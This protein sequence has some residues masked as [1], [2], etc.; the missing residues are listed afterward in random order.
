M[1]LWVL[2]KY[3][4]SLDEF[5]CEDFEDVIQLYSAHELQD[6]INRYVCLH[7]VKRLDLSNCELKQCP[8]VEVLPNLQSLN[9]DGNKITH[10]AGFE[11]NEN[12]KMLSV[13][14][15]LLTAVNIPR[16]SLTRINVG[17]DV[18]KF[19]GTQLLRA[20]LDGFLEIDVIDYHAEKLLFPKQ[21]I[22]Q[23][24]SK[25]EAFVKNPLQ[26]VLGIRD[27]VQRR[28][29]LVWMFTENLHD[30][31]DLDLSEQGEIF[32]DMPK[33]DVTAVLE[34]DCL[35]HLRHLK[36]K[37]CD[38]RNL[39]K[40]KIFD[41]LET[42]DI[43]D[44]FLD[45]FDLY[46]DSETQ[47][48]H[49]N[50]DGNP[51]ERIEID[52][53]NLPHLEVLK[54]GSVSTKYISIP[55]LERHLRGMS[56]EIEQK[57]RASLL[58]PSYNVIENDL[59][60]AFIANPEKY[61][62]QISDLSERINVL[63]WYRKDQESFRLTG[64]KDLCMEESSL[65]KLL[66]EPNLARIKRLS[67]D[68]CGLTSLPNVKH[69]KNLEVL[70][71]SENA[72]SDGSMNYK[73]LP[74]SL[75]DLDIA[76]NPIEILE[77]DAEV[78][79]SWKARDEKTLKFRC[80]SRHTK[81]ISFAL[82]D[83]FQNDIVEIKVDPEFTD[84]LL[85]P[86]YAILN[87]PNLGE[88][89]VQ[90]EQSLNNVENERDLK[91]VLHWLF[92]VEHKEFHT[93]FTICNPLCSNLNIINYFNDNAFEMVR[94]MS[95]K[96]QLSKP[97]NLSG[98]PKLTSRLVTLD[99]SDN[100]IRDLS[101]GFC[102]LKLLDTLQINDNPLEIIDFDL[103]LFP[104][105]T[106]LVCGSKETKYFR[107]SLLRGLVAQ[108]V[109]IEI[110]GDENNFLFPGR[111]YIKQG[112]EALEALCQNPEKAL[113]A[114][115]SVN[116]KKEFLDWLLRED[117]DFKSFSLVG[118][119]ELWNCQS[120]RN[121]L[122]FQLFRIE[123][124][125]L[126]SCN[127][128]E[129][130]NIK[131]YDKLKLLDLSNNSITDISNL[132][133]HKKLETFILKGNPIET[134]DSDFKCFPALSRI[135]IGSLKTHYIG[136]SLLRRMAPEENTEDIKVSVVVSCHEQSLLMPH[137]NL[138]KYGKPN[139]IQHYIKNPEQY[140]RKIPKP[141]HQ[142][143]ALKWI[144]EYHAYD[145]R[146]FQLSHQ[147]LLCKA[148]GM[149]NLNRL[150]SLL[151]NVR[152]INLQGCRLTEVPE[153][154]SLKEL[155]SLDLGFNEI[156]EM[157]NTFSHEKLKTLNIQANLIPNI[158]TDR[159][160]S[161]EE[162]HCGSKHTKSISDLAL[163][164]IK[165][166]SLKIKI[167]PSFRG[168]LQLPPYGVLDG[169]PEDIQT[170]L[171]K[172][173][174]DLSDIRTK[175]DIELYSQSSKVKVYKTL[176]MS[177]SSC[178][179]ELRNNSEFQNL[180]RQLDNI[181]S[182][183]FQDC[184]FN[185]FPTEFCFPKL[186]KI[187]LSNS[188][189]QQKVL[190]GIP[191]SVSKFVARN[192]KLR[193]LP[194]C[195]GVESLDVRENEISS[196]SSLVA[197]ARLKSLAIE[198]NRLVVVD[199]DRDIFPKLETLTCGSG[200]CRFINFS[201]LQ[202]VLSGSLTLELSPGTNLLLPPKASLD[203]TD[204]LREYVNGPERFLNHLP[205][206]DAV[207][208]LMW[209][210]AESTSNF[211]SFDLSGYGQLIEDLG[212]D[213]FQ[214]VLEME[215]LRNIKVLNLSQNSLKVLPKINCLKQVDTL[216]LSQ[217]EL[218]KFDSLL[219]HPSLTKLCLEG[220]P[221]SCLELNTELFPGLRYIRAG[222]RE[223]HTVE[224]ALL[225]QVL[226]GKI[227]L[228]IP[229]D[230]R[231]FLKFPTYTSLCDKDKLHKYLNTD[232]LDLSVSEKG[233]MRVKLIEDSIKKCTLDIVA[234]NVSGQMKL[235]EK[236]ESGLNQLLGDQNLRNVK[237][238][239]MNSCGISHFPTLK[240]MG[241][242]THL[243]LGGNQFE[244]FFINHSLRNLQ[245][246][247]LSNC[248]LDRMFSLNHFPVLK[249]LDIS[250]NRIDSDK[251][252]QFC[253]KSEKVYQLEKLNI[254]GNP[255]RE[256]NF[257]VNSFP[258][259]KEIKAGSE[260]TKFI[261]FPVLRHVANNSLSI[262]IPEHYQK[263]LLLCPFKVLNGG[264]EAINN[265]LKDTEINL[266]YIT[267]TSDRFEA[268]NWLLVHKDNTVLGVNFSGQKDFF[269]FC[270][271]K[272]NY[273]YG[274]FDNPL[275]K[276]V[277]VVYLDNC[278]LTEIP[279]MS[280]SLPKLKVLYLSNNKLEKIQPPNNLTVFQRNSSLEKLLID[281]NPVEIIDITNPSDNFPELRVLQVGSKGTHFL[282]RT[283]IDAA[284]RTAKPL[285]VK[286]VEEYGRYMTTPPYEII[287]AGPESL[288]K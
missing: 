61:S 56:L 123:S 180:F 59:V 84:E 205:R 188:D 176:R 109:T 41:S 265:Y 212:H 288:S 93:T 42:L 102:K 165:D 278:D 48:R 277:Q 177:K 6:L 159:F 133:N 131:H 92:K 83:A 230:F 95:L 138:L 37:N 35:Q 217:N 16:G 227:T 57:Y 234:L 255:Q 68:K 18:T 62:S 169:G 38:L 73:I 142:V 24:N 32:G 201:V 174:L 127:L 150:L 163:H 121:A 270:I 22:L 185:E 218:T 192:C 198:N 12:L 106:R 158:N 172:E 20:K 148:L 31:T 250:E 240:G 200:E 144:V 26:D 170:Y 72:I 239:I 4:R 179:D 183:F 226:E 101:S 223:T 104:Q 261:T 55:I 196:I 145:F 160:P 44:N 71:I 80:G 97:P 43:S 247:H 194:C 50:I 210:L 86:T 246:L 242:L 259:M 166:G 29:T 146:A 15:N 266:S 271:E 254:V 164:K 139:E 228:D 202:E 275:L 125:V 175:E 74:E 90:P 2:E 258:R 9:L 54:C 285:T 273:L 99:I 236:G 231:D 264:K 187:D 268:L 207:N 147:A 14:N 65:K 85:M 167:D 190:I 214:S 171:N 115:S 209:L 128:T 143:K 28:E 279:I 40:L 184:D 76:G 114:I 53:E 283:I 89:I 181:D 191:D 8:N 69:L 154:T 113:E 36:L 151:H 11:E 243:D 19:V 161:L 75:L 46:S 51:L 103:S 108:G 253:D 238:L 130:P 269:K 256:I 111:N 257:N 135:E 229:E 203:S 249:D 215:S 63:M 199:F 10:L 126:D 39:P 91:D 178:T 287:E 88:Y 117:V 79:Q 237:R 220:N 168:Y 129:I 27:S 1:L 107:P 248:G 149:D 67:L 13:R 213:R 189:L 119:P 70:D 136:M 182:L 87:S 52:V 140:I 17:S 157:P 100:N 232:E 221:I 280:K 45:T 225:V 124:L 155:I 197:F 34:S 241:S 208:S 219:S 112:R 33:D 77:V 47:L 260:Q 282:S 116:H 211:V 66:N 141:A 284:M 122:E 216:D 233:T 118:Q 235:A 7:S 60:H 23:D 81:F 3:H 49:L 252:R 78:L 98:L 134:I 152:E 96:C 120:I 82:L 21:S 281:G 110:S 251:M 224:K 156:V 274:M 263:Y 267:K 276:D 153:I 137:A 25:L 30:F 245:E 193:E 206:R 5:S 222:S 195:Y 94:T 173:E 64:Q 132:P 162:L 204:S 58:L 286:V 186:T 244:I 262:V 105:L 272:T